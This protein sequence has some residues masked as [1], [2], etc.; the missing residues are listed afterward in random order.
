[1]ELRLFMIEA[2][3]YWKRKNKGEKF[4]FK[5]TFIIGT[6]LL[7]LGGSVSCVYAK[8]HGIGHRRG[9]NIRWTSVEKHKTRDINARK[10]WYDRKGHIHHFYY[11]WWKRGKIIN[12]KVK[13]KQ[14]E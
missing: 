13:D 12:T 10:D 3:Y 14:N 1:M 9:H 8:R 4:M 2:Y 5:R 6:V 11:M 7:F